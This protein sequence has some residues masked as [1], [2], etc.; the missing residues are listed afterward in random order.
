MANKIIS[1][2]SSTDTKT[3]GQ[4]VYRD[5]SMNSQIRRIEEKELSDDEK[6]QNVIKTKFFV[7]KNVDIHAVETS[8]HNIFTWIPGE[9]IINPEFGSNLKKYLY[10]GITEYNQEQIVAEIRGVCMRWEPRIN[11]VDI[12]NITTI[13]DREENTVR[14]E[15]QYTIPSI[16]NEVRNYQF[17]L[18][19]SL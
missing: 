11:I 13:Q 10:E 8:L 18:N 3:G 17:T 9:R 14:L 6:I 7:D 12:K 5:I 19:R 16:S 2:G 15:V 1:F 4:Y